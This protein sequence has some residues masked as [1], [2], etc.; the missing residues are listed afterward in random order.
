MAPG[1]PPRRT[2]RFTDRN[3]QTSC[4]DVESPRSVV[5]ARFS[6]LPDNRVLPTDRDVR[7]GKFS[8]PPGEEN[9]PAGSCTSGGKKSWRPTPARNTDVVEKRQ[10]SSRPRD[11]HRVALLLHSRRTSCFE[12]E[13]RPAPTVARWRGEKGKKRRE[14]Y[15]FDTG[16]T[17]YGEPNTRK[18]AVREQLGLYG[19]LRKFRRGDE[20]LYRCWILQGWFEFYLLAERIIRG[21]FEEF[22]RLSVGRLK[23]EDVWSTYQRY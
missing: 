20:L 21:Q 17:G 8:L 7:P 19:S 2:T 12:K 9:D 11:F 4:V 16:E 15:R 23:F 6:L 1:R 13:R 18:Q 5:L 10:A 14:N 3:D 22:F